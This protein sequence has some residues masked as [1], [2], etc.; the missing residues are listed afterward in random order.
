MNRKGQT[1]G[2]KVSHY[3]DEL[4]RYL[5]VDLFDFIIVNSQEPPQELIDVYAEEG[6]IVDNDLKDERIRSAHL[7]GEL[8]RGAKRDLIKRNLIRHDPR[9]LAQELMKIVNHL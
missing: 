6:D 7:L 5:G 2:F 9:K 3:L 1:T 8:N 4:I